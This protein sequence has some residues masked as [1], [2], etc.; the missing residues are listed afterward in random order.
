MIEL[1]EDKNYHRE[2]EWV[3]HTP[4]HLPTREHIHIYANSIS[5]REKNNTRN[6]D[7]FKAVH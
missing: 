7:Q 3:N 2:E 5:H 6:F 1:D 4:N